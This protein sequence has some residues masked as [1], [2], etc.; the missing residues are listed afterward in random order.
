MDLI[1]DPA[2]SGP[3]NMARDELLLTQ[4]IEYGRLATRWYA[5]SPATLSLGYFQ[6][7]EPHVRP[8]LPRVR[9]LSGGGAII[10]DVEWTYSLAA[11][12]GVL[13]ESTDL[14]ARVHEAILAETAA[15]GL[16]LAMRGVDERELDDR[17]LCFG[18]GDRHDIL[19][20]GTKVVGSAQRRRGGAVLQHGSI[21]VGV[22]IDGRTIGQACD[23][24]SFAESVA[25]RLVG[26]IE[27]RRVE[28]TAEERE[29]ADAWATRKY[30]HLD[31]QGPLRRGPAAVPRPA[32][33][34]DDGPAGGRVGAAFP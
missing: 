20:G 21:A 31:W 3:A 24:Q 33:G 16:L 23:F 15:S 26:P 10:H 6:S 7:D 22:D 19:T 9:R 13:G 28:W 5:W 25:R 34:R 17:F 4:A 29:A 32:T 8:D 14:Y 12:S 1:L 11:P 27:L 18:R 30:G 2:L